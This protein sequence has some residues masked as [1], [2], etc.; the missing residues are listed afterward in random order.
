MT[1][2]PECLALRYWTLELDTFLYLHAIK[3][4]P[5][6]KLRAAGNHMYH[7]VSIQSTKGS[8]IVAFSKHI[9]KDYKSRISQ[10]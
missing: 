3:D 4:H 7:L 1:A 9:P 2:G 8:A 6:E 10:M 5:G